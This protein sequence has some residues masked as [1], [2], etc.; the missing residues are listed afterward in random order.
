MARFRFQ[1]SAL[2]VITG[3]LLMSCEYRI[4][5]SSPESDPSSY[6]YQ[7]GQQLNFAIVSEQV[8][9]PKCLHCHSDAQKNSGGVNLERF[10]S[11]LSELDDI[12]KDIRSGE[13]PKAPV[14]PLSLEEKNL[15]LAWIQMGAPKDSAPINSN[16]EPTPAPIPT[17]SPVERDIPSVGLE[18]KFSSIFNLII[19]VK[20]LDCH[21]AGGDAELIP[22]EKY[23]DI[24]F[25]KMVIPKD[26]DHSI[27][28][29]HLKPNAKKVI[30]AEEDYNII[31]DWIQQG[32]QDN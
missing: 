21:Q 27:L 18:P 24:V 3:T 12:S 32:A 31:I 28:P 20:C 5:K 23:S 17:S 8:L 25:G 9:K 15:L 4:D 2:L 6:Q 29:R 26:P 19:K 14:Q 16:P 22:F 7:K 1:I 11:V 30:L 10:D 13:M